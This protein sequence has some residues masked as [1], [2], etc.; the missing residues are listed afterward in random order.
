[1]GHPS[2]R[3]LKI[4]SGG[5]LVLA[6]VWQHTQATR[7]GYQVELSRGQAHILRGRISSLRMELE[8]SLSPGQLALRARSKLGMFP[9]APESLRILGQSP[10]AAPQETLLGRLLPKSW[11]ALASLLNT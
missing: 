3:T 6:L 10:A 9:A 11:R 5:L 2:R 7:L 1:M 8:T 4:L